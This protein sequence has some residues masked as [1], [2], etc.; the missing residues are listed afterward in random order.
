MCCIASNALK[1]YPHTTL[2]LLHKCL[3]CAKKSQELSIDMMRHSFLQNS[4]SL[5]IYKSVFANE[6]LVFRNAMVHLSDG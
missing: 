4:L 2:P 6:T 3:V 1:L 5:K